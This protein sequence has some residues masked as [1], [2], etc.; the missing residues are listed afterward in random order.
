MFRLC[1]EKASCLLAPLSLWHAP[2][3]SER[4][5]LNFS[6]AWRKGTGGGHSGHR[7]SQV[8]TI[9]IECFGRN[10][11]KF[12]PRA[13]IK[14]HVLGPKL[15]EE[16]P[17]EG[18][19]ENR[20][21]RTSNVEK[22][23]L[24]RRMWRRRSNSRCDNLNHSPFYSRDYFG[25]WNYYAD[26]PHPIHS[27][28]LFRN[29]KNHLAHATIVRTLWIA[30][31]VWWSAGRSRQRSIVSTKNVE[32]IDNLGARTP[33]LDIV[34]ED[35]SG[36]ARIYW[37]H[38]EPWPYEANGKNALRTANEIF[39]WIN[40][41]IFILLFHLSGECGDARARVSDWNGANDQHRLKIKPSSQYKSEIITRLSFAPS[42]ELIPARNC[43][44][45]V[46]SANSRIFSFTCFA[47][48]IY[49]F[50][51][52][53]APQ[54]EFSDTKPEVKSSNGLANRKSLRQSLMHRYSGIYRPPEEFCSSKFAVANR[55]SCSGRRKNG[56]WR[57]CSN[58]FSNIPALIQWK[59]RRKK[60]SRT[61]HTQM[62][63]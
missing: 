38:F 4:I 25:K 22:L 24:I 9:R 13:S 32:I 47:R 57:S 44:N 52:G 51:V 18:D 2:R 17:K 37:I 27:Y 50:V 61:N 62:Q 59:R 23:W 21:R 60:H 63:M 26:K 55:L 14:S 54:I 6:V 16:K 3:C 49:G 58:P 40:T 15:N 31:L 29:A 45:Q 20:G 19:G 28:R 41:R 46:W 53:S 10:W 30:F 48:I 36:V 56:S 34:N 43:K 1:R 35:T 33:P 5:D 7:F 42:A 12:R 39:Q 8:H 11:I